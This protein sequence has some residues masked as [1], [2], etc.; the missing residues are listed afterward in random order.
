MVKY[1]L[2][3]APPSSDHGAPV[4]QSNI[5][6]QSQKRPKSKKTQHQHPGS[7]PVADYSPGFPQGEYNR[8]NQRD[9]MIHKEKATPLLGSRNS[10]CVA[11]SALSRYVTDSERSGA[12]SYDAIT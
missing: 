10:C 1:I 9:G 12:T 6:T 2:C 7:L 8:V 11:T 4:T 3:M 5:W